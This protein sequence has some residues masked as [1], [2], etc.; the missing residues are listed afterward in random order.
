MPNLNIKVDW[1]NE[2]QFLA[3]FHYDVRMPQKL[4]SVLKY[5]KLIADFEL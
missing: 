3:F 4:I 1:L 5:R 2:S